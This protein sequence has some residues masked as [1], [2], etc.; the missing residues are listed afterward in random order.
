MVHNTC[1][2][3]FRQHC[4]CTSAPRLNILASV[5]STTVVP[6]LQER[7]GITCFTSHIKWLLARNHDDCHTHN[8]LSILSSSTWHMPARVSTLFYVEVH[9]VKKEHSK[10]G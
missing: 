5:W 6:G 3:F 10:N 9:G 8:V 2:L 1:S 4:I 7:S